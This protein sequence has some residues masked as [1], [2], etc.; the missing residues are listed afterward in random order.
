MQVHRF[1][2]YVISRILTPAGAGRPAG[3]PPTSRSANIV[4]TLAGD[5]ITT[6][7]S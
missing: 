4:Q 6:V 5:V 1:D 2:L 7:A 3:A